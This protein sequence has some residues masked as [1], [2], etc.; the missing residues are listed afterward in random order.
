VDTFAS[1]NL[2]YGLSEKSDGPMKGDSNNQQTFFKRQNLD[3]RKIIGASLIHGNNIVIVDSTTTQSM[4]SDCDALI[5][6]DKNCL[7]TVTVADCLP[8]YFYDSKKQLIALAH[9]GWKGVLNGIAQ[10]TAL[11]LINNFGCDPTDIEILIGPHIQKCHFEI[12]DD[13]A[14]QFAP[15]YLIKTGDKKYINL[16]DAVKDQL[17]KIEL[18]VDNISISPEC[19]FCLDDKYF[20][21]R[22]ERDKIIKAM[23]AYIGLN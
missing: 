3:K 8:I 7:L 6:A 14:S 15:K 13:V 9:A 11:L 22:R 10:K 4:I 5:T 17:L 23:V 12:Q 19:T 2:I 20:S 18:P 21:F 1:S 16:S